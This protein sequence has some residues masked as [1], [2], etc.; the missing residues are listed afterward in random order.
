M[1]ILGLVTW[2]DVHTR[3]GKA[4]ER[5]KAPHANDLPDFDDHTGPKWMAGCSTLW[6]EARKV[7]AAGEQGWPWLSVVAGMLS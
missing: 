5:G 2:I 7:I 6:C 4:R 1:V 3:S